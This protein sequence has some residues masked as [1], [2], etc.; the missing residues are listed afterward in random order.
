MINNGT[1]QGNLARENEIRTAAN[2][3]KVLRNTIA[4]RR[5]KDNTDWIDFVAF[6]KTAELIASYTTKGSQLTISGPIQTGSFDRK[7]GTKQK[8]WEV[9]VNQVGLPP[10][11]QPR[12]Q[13]E[14]VE[15][16]QAMRESPTFDIQR[17]DLPF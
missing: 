16:E 2:G 8:T 4:V 11:E 15:W 12:A 13:Q 14:A 7:D 5:D 3:T 17:D 9:V 10:K 6:N 1:W